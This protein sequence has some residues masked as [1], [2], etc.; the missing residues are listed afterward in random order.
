MV[1]T[2]TTRPLTSVSKAQ[3]KEFQEEHQR[4]DQDPQK[5]D[6]LDPPQENQEVVKQEL[7]D[8]SNL[9]AIDQSPKEQPD[10]MDPRD[11]QD[12]ENGAWAELI[13]LPPWTIL[14]EDHKICHASK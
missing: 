7:K 13:C 3:P 9:A 8:H 14:S 5:E 2:D 4:E 12:T 6:Q 10:L 1:Y 11:V